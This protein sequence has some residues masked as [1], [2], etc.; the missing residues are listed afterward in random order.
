[1]LVLTPVNAQRNLSGTP[2]IK[3]ALERLPVMGS[4]LM[5]AAHPDDENTALL[6]YYARGRKMRTAYLSLTRGEGGQNLIGSERG[7]A[8][9]IIRTQE[10][11]AARRIDGA[12]Q[13]FTRAIDFGF[14]KT[15]DETLEKWGR[16][17][18]LG[19][20]VWVIR[21]FRPDVIILRFSGTPRDGHGHHQSSAILGKEAFAAAAD[22]KRFPEQLQWVKPWQATR[23]LFNVFSFTPRDE[24]A[25]AAIPGRL[26]IDAGAYDPVLGKSYTEIAGAS[27][28][29]HR[30]QG[31]GAPERRGPFRNFLTW[32]SGQTAQHDAF[33][34]IDIT[35]N[36]LPGGAAAGS[37][38]NEAANSFVPEHPEKTIPLLLKARPLIKAIDDPWAKMKL[39]DLDETIALC[40]GLWAEATSV[41]ANV[42]P[43][44]SIQIEASAINRSPF[45]MKW[46]SA[47]L[48]ADP[49]I[50]SAPEALAYN[51]PQHATLTWKVPADHAYSQPF[52][53]Q[54]PP[55]HDLYTIDRQELVGLADSP[56]VARVR[57]HF[58]VGDAEIELM[59]PVEYRH[60]DR[61]EGELTQPLAVVPPIA[62]NLRQAALLFPDTHARQ[63]QVQVKA[64]TPQAS[65]E[66]RLDLAAGWSA[67]PK[68]RSFQLAD[69][70]QEEQL[71]FEIRPPAKEGEGS[72]RAVASVGGREVAFG[73][74]TIA[75]THIPAQ[76]LFP[77]SRARLERVDVS[78]R[79]HKVG[80]VMGAGD[81]I[82]DALRQIG[83]EVTLLSAEDLA[84]RD[85]SS[86]NAIVTGVRAFNTRPELRANYQR[87]LDYV[88]GGGTLIVQYNVTEGGGPFNAP[89]TGVL[90]HLGPYPLK[91]GRDRV[92]VEEAP[93]MFANPDHPLLQAPNH[94]GVREFDGWVQERGLY[95]ASEWDPKYQAVFETHDPGE[96]PLTGGLLYTHYGKGIYIFTAFSWFRQLPEGVP[97]AYRIFANLLS[98]GA[99]V[100]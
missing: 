78:I 86:F 76:T 96:K 100:R 59:R 39:R 45:P 92:T 67:E 63:V 41:H 56:P 24:A 10:L 83:C 77:D 29:M 21:R 48:D 58:Q 27:R 31:M 61:V 84:Q 46:T 93:V 72:L 34:A 88:K 25:A 9:G 60:V 80:Y 79:A 36:R 52:W 99:V 35:W 14:S 23:L 54:K 70:G 98:A 30:S 94:I 18:V 12:E 66:L 89:D 5:I 19:D 91:I 32:V 53:L 71:S 26:E 73:M 95:F 11:L 17:K 40:A 64:N 74:E 42:V 87:L 68:S 50:A 85:F 82:P 13:F 3:L 2:E 55:A 15:A 97:G 51:Q 28:S 69:A 47:A 62:V 4:V 8:L 22:P 6:A 49:S 38:L 81:E 43:G 37:I 16:E 90:A 44:T 20:I 1:M 33:D 65:G 75:F 57:F 7:A